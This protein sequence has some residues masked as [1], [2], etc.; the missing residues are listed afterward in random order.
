MSA[1]SETPVARSR[2]T[3]PVVEARCYIEGVWLDG[4]GETIERRSPFNGEVVSHASFATTADVDAAVAAARRAHDA[5]AET[6]VAS[7]A[8]LLRRAADVLVERAE[9]AAR[10]ISREMGKT[11][12]EAREDVEYAA[13][14]MRFAAEDALRLFGQVSPHTTDPDRRQKRVL[15]VHVPVGVAALLSPWNFPIAIPCELIS[16]ALACGN[17]VVFKPSEAAPGSGHLLVEVLAEAGFPPGV[18]NC[19]QGAG[20]IGGALVSHPGTDMVG[21]VGSTATGE[22]IARTAGVKKLLLE[23]GGNGPIV[24]MEDADL[25]KAVEATLVGAYYC[26]GQVCTAAERVLVHDAVH[27]VYVEKLVART[28]EVRMGDPLDPNTDMGPLAISS[29]LEKTRAHLDDAIA[30]GAKIMVGGSH[31]G[32]FHEPTV[33]T[34]VT[35]DMEIAQEETFGPVVPVMRFSD[36]DEAVRIANETKYGLTGAVFTESLS[37]AWFM[38]EKLQCG[39]VHVNETTNHWELLSPFG[40]VK[41]SGIGRILGDQSVRTFTNPKQITFELSDR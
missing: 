29:S 22:R 32:L 39:T 26:G 31:D 13:D 23:L 33:V 5:W 17:T 7:R 41:Q 15:T 16:P 2:G 27:D 18:F 4:H 1:T 21:F 8:K 36:R 34:G 3:D 38:A 9:E 28:K 40:G 19:L 20:D 12:G 11:I 37:T 14:D 30:K 6:A 35:S 25:E 10:L 24:V